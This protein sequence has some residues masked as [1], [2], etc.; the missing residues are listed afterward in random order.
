MTVKTIAECDRL[1]SAETPNP[2]VCMIRLCDRADIPHELRF[3]FHTVWLRAWDTSIPTVFGHR[4]CDFSDGTMTLLQPGR[5]AT[6]EIWHP[7]AGQCRGWLLGFHDSV[8]DP[9]KAG[10]HCGGYSFFRYDA[11]ESLHLS[12]R[13]MAVL[14]RAMEEIGEELHWGVDE[15]CHRILGGRIRLLLDYASRFYRRQFILRHDEN[16][17]MLERTDRALELFFREGKARRERL[18]SSEYLALPFGCSPDYFNDMLRHETG[19]DAEE[20]VL[21]KQIS[22]AERMLRSRAASVGEVAARLGFPSDRAFCSLFRRLKGNTPDELIS[23]AGKRC[24]N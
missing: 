9:L 17:A 22:I 23:A 18:P 8:F 16:M 19:K 15:Y 1:F 20:Y 12:Q 3:G 11:R 24:L 2:Q 10:R 6:S 21:F 7:Q 13:E 14:E 5:A 4:E